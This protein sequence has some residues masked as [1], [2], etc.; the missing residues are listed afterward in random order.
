MKPGW[1]IVGG[2]VLLLSGWL[3]APA[4]GRR[5]AYFD[6]RSVEV[7]GARHVPVKAV[8]Q[9]LKLPPSASVFDA[10][11]PV[12]ARV[13]K[14]PGI[15]AA[16]VTR[17]L[18]G[19]L[20]VKV[21]ESAPVALVSSSQGLRMVDGRGRA[22]PY[23]PTRAAPDLPLVPAADTAVASLLG[24]V[25]ELDPEFYADVQAAWRVKED[26]VLRL[27]THRVWLRPG[28]GADELMALR[29]VADDLRRRG[30]PFAALDARF[31]DQV[32]VRWSD[33]A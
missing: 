24:R 28:A 20:V 21:Q 31:A 25:R 27:R 17:R 1:P 16:E 23:D 12:E 26:V 9:S 3:G 18:P 22:L 7:V 10:L 13:R 19:T 32:V 8:V 5:L 6:V 14:V 4:L 29:M 33:S 11:A 15:R 30:R 2:A